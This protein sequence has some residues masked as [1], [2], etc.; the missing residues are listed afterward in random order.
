MTKNE[1]IKEIKQSMSPIGLADEEA[2]RVA[3]ARDA[4]IKA[5]EDAERYRR[6]VS[7]EYIIGIIDDQLGGL[8][9]VDVL[10]KLARLEEYEKLGTV[11]E[12]K[13]AKSMANACEQIRWERDVAISQLEEVGVSLGQKM[14]DIRKLQEKSVAKQPLFRLC[15][16]CKA[17][18]CFDCERYVNRCP[19]CHSSLYSNSG[20]AYKHCPECGQ[21]LLNK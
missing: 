9:I 14:N 4:A 20:K 13:Q 2:R 16:E 10:T 3:E 1:V 5:L 19:A 18:E 15:E 12:T 8:D 6:I 17:D 7:P 21:K 11:E